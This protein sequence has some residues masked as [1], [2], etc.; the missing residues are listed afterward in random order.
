MND[1]DWNRA[2]AFL[3][4]AETGS[5]SAAARQL[6]LTQPTLSR[7]VAA[8]EAELG[9]TLF[10]RL[11]KKLSL[12]ETGTSLLAHVRTMGEAAGAMRLAASGRAQDI[13]GRV[14]ISAT[15]AYAAYVLPDLVARIRREAPQ[16]TLTVIST[17]SLSDLRRREADIA[18]RHLRPV[19]D[20]LIGQL[21]GESR[22][23]LYAAPGW[24]ARHRGLRSI[25]DIP[26][27]ELIGF[28]EPQRFTQALREMG[29]QVTDADLR[30]MSNSSVMIWE[31]VRRGLGVTV[32][33][34]EI[35]D[36]T[37]GVIRIMTDMA[38]PR[39][40]IWLVTHRELRTSRRIRLVYDILAGELPRIIAG[41]STPRPRDPIT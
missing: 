30:L 26:P 31:M 33:L 15:D 14:S 2:R 8:L 35:G 1:L 12:T 5:L 11:G 38:L 10:E 4:T 25:T 23:G 9:V 13:A 39:F 6:G 24:L 37:P 20:G 17:N 34:R 21:L 41:T 28:D 3:A 27:Q 32:M 29:L 16:I 40:P 22:A 19:D 7:Q 18:L 36:R